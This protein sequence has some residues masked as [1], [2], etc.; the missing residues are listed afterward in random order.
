MSRAL[1]GILIAGEDGRDNVLQGK[2]TVTIRYGYREYTEGPVLI[3]CH[4]LS[5]AMLAKITKVEYF[6][7]K[8]VPLSD[9]NGD[10]YSSSSEAVEDLSRW[11]PDI[12]EDSLVTVVRWSN[13]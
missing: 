7:L 13:K 8:D 10:G 5:W 9:L 4:H 11:Y 1:Q 3:G 2:Q 6:K 12:T